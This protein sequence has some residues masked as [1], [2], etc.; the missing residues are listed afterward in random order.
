MRS[1]HAEATMRRVLGGLAVLVLLALAILAGVVVVR[2]VRL[3]AAAPPPVEPAPAVALDLRAAAERLGAALRFRTISSVDTTQRADAEF[4]A[5][6]AFL[7]Q[8]FPTV[9]TRLRREAIGGLSLLYT[10]PGSDPALP[11]LLVLAHQDVVPVET[12]TEGRW[13]HPPFAGVVAE[14]YVWGR[15]A[16]DDKSSLMAQL[17]AVEGLL[18]EGF[19]PRRTVLLAF[20][21]DEEI[22]GRSGAAAI[23]AE[24]RRRGVRP[25]LVLDEGG[26][27][28]RGLLPVDRPVALVGVAE[29]GYV[30]LEFRATAP[31][32]HS[33]M[34]P[35]RTALG[36]V[37]EAVDRLQQNPFPASLRE[38]ARSMLL[39]V[40][41]AMPLTARIALANL[42]L[43]EP[44]V[45][46]RLTATPAGNAALRTT[47]APTMAE[48]SVK[49]NVLPQRA[50]IVVNFRIAPGDRV[51]TVLAHAQRA[52]AGTGVCL[53]I[54]NNF[55]SEPSALAPQDT[56][57][58]WLTRTI[59]RVRPDALVAP[60]LVLG[61]T[62][63]RHYAGLTPH[64][65]RFLPVTMT[66]EDL[67]R[68]H[69]TDERIA[70]DDYARMIRFYRQLIL[71]LD[72]T[73]VP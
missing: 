27:V 19:R 25:L 57:F 12:G 71:D 68:V 50:R 28:G 63:S 55:A 14:G 38:P 34:P 36:R 47:I 48:G 32:G 17:E 65:Y 67:R 45:V 21:H 20:G 54:V 51:A 73:A 4:Q 8:A 26:V 3:R 35:E 60:Y 39:A 58:A 7:T 41:P 52:A 13:T 64:V 72:G 61:A 33:S 69:G 49:D 18:R 6:H 24:L 40:A 15:G 1:F 2:A 56:V 16:L 5:F 10:W 37:V 42:W 53:G 44:L 31:G 11:P 46:R 22:G 43:F 29:K 70:V 59:R 62:D 9:H 30:S 23:A 66:A